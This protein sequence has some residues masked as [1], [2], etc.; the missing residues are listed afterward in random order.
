MTFTWAVV[1]GGSCTLGYSI[2]SRDSHLL[3][4]VDSA[5]KS[6][7]ISNY[8]NTADACVAADKLNSEEG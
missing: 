8:S 2:N 1:T 5:Q 7:T 4:A 3:M 6:V